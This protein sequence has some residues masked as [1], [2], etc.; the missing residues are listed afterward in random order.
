MRDHER[1]PISG[2]I[3]ASSL[4]RAQCSWNVRDDHAGLP[5]TFNAAPT[6]AESA[7]CGKAIVP[8]RSSVEPLLKSAEKRE[9]RDKVSRLHR[10]ATTN[11][12]KTPLSSSLAL[13]EERQ[14]MAFR[15]R[16]Y[17]S[18]FDAKTR[19]PVRGL[20]RGTEPARSAGARRSWRLQALIREGGNFPSAGTGATTR[21]VSSARQFR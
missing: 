6:A 18:R 21:E 17:R 16:A 7:A 5:D 10:P 11:E 19:K 4:R 3:S 8:S 20:R 15:L 14:I 1:L 12:R 2:T 9:L 13:R